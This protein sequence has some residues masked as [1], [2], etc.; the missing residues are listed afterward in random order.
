MTLAG[1]GIFAAIKLHIFEF[2][3]SFER[4]NERI[5][6]VKQRLAILIPEKMTFDSSIFENPFNFIVTL[7]E[8]EGGFLW[9]LLCLVLIITVISTLGQS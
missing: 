6:A 9:T 8:G 5:H 2:N 3:K 4:L 7:F 1:I